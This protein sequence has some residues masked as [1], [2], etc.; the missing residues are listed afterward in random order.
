MTSLGEIV[1]HIEG[2][3]GHALNAD[4]GVHLGDPAV[5]VSGVTVAWMASPD[6][7]EAAGRRGDQVLMCHESL[8]YPYNAA[9]AP[10]ADLGWRDWKV[11]R[12]RREALERFGLTCI[13]IH[14][15]ADEISIFDAFTGRLGLGAPVVV[16]GLVKV[17]EIPE[18]SLGELVRTVKQRMG[19]P[20]IRVAGGDDAARRV[21]RVGVPWGGLGLFV[22]VSYQ[23]RLVELGCDVFI[24]GESDSYGFHF[25][26]ESG[27]PMIE[28]S[29]ED[30]E[31]PGL[32]LF[33]ERL[34]RAFP[35]V[36]F[37]FHENVCVWRAE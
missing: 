27:I 24:A 13:R 34:A 7:I 9:H 6:A 19:M 3:S 1:R 25:A 35:D 21:R 16:E 5:A 36:A 11:N 14:A 18:C 32:R 31:N 22:N 23:Q 2:L 20:V 15:S 37:H 8:Y 12:Q 30:S 28:T 26:V 4:E 33:T 29:H 10:P 17:Y